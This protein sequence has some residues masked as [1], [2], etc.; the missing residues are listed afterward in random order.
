MTPY[1]SKTINKHGTGHSKVNSANF[2]GVLHENDDDISDNE[3]PSAQPDARTHFGW[4]N[5]VTVGRAAVST[6]DTSAIQLLF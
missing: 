1:C 4:V 3:K 5:D 6:N 2:G